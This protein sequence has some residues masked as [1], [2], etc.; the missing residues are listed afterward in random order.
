MKRKLF[1]ALLAALLCLSLVLCVHASPDLLVDDADLLTASEAQTLSQLLDEVS[2]ELDMDVV[3]LTVEDLDGRSPKRFAQDYYDDNG[4]ADTGVLF[5]VSMAD[6]DWYICT[7][8]D[9]RVDTDGLSETFLPDLSNGDYLNAFVAFARNLDAYTS[10]NQGFSGSGWIIALVIGVVVAFVVVFIM[11]AQLKSV[12][13]QAA[14]NSYV[15]DGSFNLTHSRDI[16]LYRRVSRTPKPQSNSSS[17]R[18]HG[19]GGGKF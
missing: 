17:G 12:R 4:Y 6:R 19:G 18:R 5:L 11:K 15:L 1:S 3:V 10:S 2:R 8:G 7:T 13:P 14:A 9:I 16:F